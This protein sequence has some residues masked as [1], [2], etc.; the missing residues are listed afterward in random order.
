MRFEPNFFYSVKVSIPIILD[1]IF[2][3]KNTQYVVQGS[4]NPYSQQKPQN[5]NLENT[6]NDRKDI[7]TKKVVKSIP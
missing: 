7:Y 2:F 6:R 5:E 3:Q 4:K 1:N